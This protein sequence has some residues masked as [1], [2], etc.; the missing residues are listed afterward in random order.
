MRHPKTAPIGRVWTRVLQLVAEASLLTTEGV[1]VFLRPPPAGRILPTARERGQAL[2]ICKAMQKRG[3]LRSVRPWRRGEIWAV[4]EAGQVTLAG[5]SRPRGRH[6]K[7]DARYRRRMKRRR[8]GL[9]A[10]R[11]CITASAHGPATHGCR[12]EACAIVHRRSA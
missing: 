1:S 12:C 9:R 7:T 5:L 6:Y 3:Y 2:V 4:D 11:L 8:D 10:A